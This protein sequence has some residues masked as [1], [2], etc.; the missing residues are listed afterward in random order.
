MYLLVYIIAWLF[1]HPGICGATLQ[2]LVDMNKRHGGYVYRL[3]FGPFRPAVGL[4]H[5]DTVKL[6][7]R[8]AEPKAVRGNG[9]YS[10]VLPFLGWSFASISRLVLVLSFLDWSSCFCFQ[11]GPAHKD[12]YDL[13]S[14]L[15]FRFVAE[16]NFLL[17]FLVSAFLFPSFVLSLL[18]FLFDLSYVLYFNYSCCILYYFRL[19][20][21]SL[22]LL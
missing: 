11:V 14:L 20:I 6:I 21:C 13:N 3:W 16:F 18:I 10:L 7:L 4:N 8:T 9:A 2:W 5:P 17:F 12:W 19:L 22:H 15:S 1:Q